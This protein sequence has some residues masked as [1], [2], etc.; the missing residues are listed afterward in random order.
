MDAERLH[1]REGQRGRVTLFIFA[2]FDASSSSSVGL[3]PTKK[4]KE[5]KKRVD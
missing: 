2:A 4:K 3:P 5:E 1:A